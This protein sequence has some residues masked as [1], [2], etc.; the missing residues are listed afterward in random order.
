MKKTRKRPALKDLLRFQRLFCIATAAA[1][2][3]LSFGSFFILPF[4]DDLTVFYNDIPKEDR[5]EFKE[6]ASLSLDPITSGAALIRMIS[7]SSANSA[8]I[9]RV[10]YAVAEDAHPSMSDRAAGIAYLVLDAFDS[11]FSIGIYYVLALF[12]TITT[13]ITVAIALGFMLYRYREVSEKMTEHILY[14]G[15]MNLTR[16]ILCRLPLLVLL[17]ALVPRVRFGFSAYAFMALCGACIVMNM[18]CSRLKD[19]TRAQRKYRNMIQITSIFG[20]G[21]FIAFCI[22]LSRSHFVPKAIELF[23]NKSLTDVFALFAGGKFD[24]DEIISFLAG[25]AIFFCLLGVCK[26][27]ANNLCRAGLTT[28]RMKKRDYSAGDVYIASTI[29]PN[30]ILL[31]MWLLMNTKAE[32]IFYNAEKGYMIATAALIVSMTL[33]EIM[34]KVFKETICVDLGDGGKDTVL[35]GNTYNAQIEANLSEEMKEAK[36]KANA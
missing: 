33:T 4:T 9:E 25:I 30:V 28:T 3:I 2:L 12:V 26:S 14:K 17:K 16:I 36:E 24:M 29:R 18:V 19:Y 23:E 1:M 6:E 32:L 21:I 34:I 15:V 11:D 8:E 31:V 7:L 27:F 20:I 35:E 5:A 10:Y 13:P 22:T